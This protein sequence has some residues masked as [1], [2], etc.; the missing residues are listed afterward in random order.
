MNAS[1]LFLVG[2]LL[3]A[4]L[5]GCSEQVSVQVNCE[6]VAGPAVECVVAESVGKAEVEA[7]WDFSVLCANGAEVKAERTCHK[8]KDGATD[9]VV[10]PAEKL[11]GIDKCGGS[12][13]P[14]AKMSGLTLNGKP[15]G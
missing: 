10:I 13:P 9:K 11:S 2:V 7:C 8:V 14:T 15:T 12:G 3:G 1:R 5:T 6:S 4:G